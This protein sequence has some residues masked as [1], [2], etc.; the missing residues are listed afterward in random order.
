MRLFL[1]ICAQFLSGSIWFAANA[2]FLDQKFLLSAV[3]AGF[4]AGTLCFAFFNLSDRFSPARVF[5]ACSIAG[6][7]CNL[8]GVLATSPI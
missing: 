2:A 3:Q 7:V 1:I 6:A 4:I 8:A 5:F